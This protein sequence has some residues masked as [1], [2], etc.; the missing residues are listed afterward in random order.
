VLATDEK[1]D[2]RWAVVYNKNTSAQTISK[3]KNDKEYI[4]RRAVSSLKM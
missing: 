1:V 2:V 3:L 4:V